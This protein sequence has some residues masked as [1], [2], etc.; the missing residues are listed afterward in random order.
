MRF[1]PWGRVVALSALLVVGGALALGVGAIASTR[2]RLV[3]YPVT[4]PVEGLAFDLGDADVV[5]VGAGQA[6]SVGVERTE[7]FAFGHDADTRESVASGVFRVRSRCPT[8]LLGACSVSYRL[9]VPDNVP[10]DVRTGS[11]NVT[12]R[13]YRGSARLQTGAGRI[14]V[15]GYCGNVLDARTGDGDIV[16][17]ADCAPPKASLR[18]RDGAIRATVPRGRYAIDAESTTGSEAVHGLAPTPDA[19]YSLQALSGSGDI[20]IEGRA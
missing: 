11:G 16:L 9:A 6:A 1:S 3:S 15:S 20:S 17:D 4:G 12:L 8:S 2:E 14:D 19:P 13:G 18:T 10:L 7:R 5:I